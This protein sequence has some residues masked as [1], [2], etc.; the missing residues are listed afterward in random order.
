MPEAT[1]NELLDPAKRGA[2]MRAWL[3]LEQAAGAQLFQRAAFS[4]FATGDDQWTLAR[5]QAIAGVQDWCELAELG[6]A[7]NLVL[8]GSVGTGK[9]HLAIA[10]LKRLIRQ[11]ATARVAMTNGRDMA[12]AWRDA[13]E[14]KTSAELFRRLADADYL[15]LSDPLPTIGSL[16]GFQA[17]QLYRLTRSR[18]DAGKPTICTLN[19]DDENDADNRLGAATW[20]RLN[21][22]AVSIR[23]EWRS[24]RQPA[25]R[26][27]QGE[28]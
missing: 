16:S 8:W 12:A 15:L 3:K 5:K 22:G 19:I 1:R 26:I 4:T 2:A 13:I 18:A 23:C 27:N 24:F 7:G 21:G 9:D 6:Q 28:A 11:G 10:A 17:D 20:D 14:T 25:A